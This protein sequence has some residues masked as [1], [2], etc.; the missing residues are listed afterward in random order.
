MSTPSPRGVSLLTIDATTSSTTLQVVVVTL[1]ISP[2]RSVARA[3]P[4]LPLP[5]GSYPI[6]MP[7]IDMASGSRVSPARSIFL[8]H[9][10]GVE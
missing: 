5:P 7:V 3:T 6:T 2:S 4:C 10:T 1:R 9:S 8:S